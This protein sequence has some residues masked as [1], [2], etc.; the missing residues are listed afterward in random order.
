MTHYYYPYISVFKA[1]ADET[2]L[3]I[4]QM[5]TY[6]SMCATDLLSYFNISQPSLS[7]HMHILTGSGLVS[8]R[9]EAGRTMYRVRKDKLEQIK[10]LMETFLEGT[11]LD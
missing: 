10:R 3:Q 1:L 11:E 9:R 8:A 2:R 5:L 4:V 7:Y 6:E